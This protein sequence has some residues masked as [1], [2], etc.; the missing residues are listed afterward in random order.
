MEFFCYHRDRAGS[1]TLRNELREEHWSYMDR[2]AKELIAR[3]PTYTGD[4][5]TGSVHIVDRAGSYDSEEPRVG[6]VELQARVAAQPQ[7]FRH[8]HR[9]AT[10]RQQVLAGLGRPQ[11][12]VE[13]QSLP[14]GQHGHLAA[15]VV[16]SQAPIE[17]MEPS[18][19][20]PGQPG[21]VPGAQR[22]PAKGIG[23]EVDDLARLAG[24]SSFTGVSSVEGEHPAQHIVRNH[25]SRPRPPGR[26][27]RRGHHVDLRQARQPLGVGVTRASEDPQPAAVH[28]QTAAIQDNPAQIRPGRDL[29]LQQ[30]GTA[31]L[32]IAG[33]H[34][35][36]YVSAGQLL[37]KERPGWIIDVDQ[38]IDL[39][40]PRIVA[41]ALKT[42]SPGAPALQSTKRDG[43]LGVRSTGC[44]SV[45]W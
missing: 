4:T 3:G 13:R 22:L 32:G 27:E 5:P 15:P 7:E 29:E 17:L 21:R 2:Y 45:L 16:P 19:K 10:G 39:A 11:R 37:E 44:Y 1:V 23:G 25:E 31:C 41:P 38:L 9:T 33:Q 28:Q 36:W 34:L 35:N 26:I 8:G 12:R 43:L 20:N 42:Q 30:R 14:A 40:H 6:A 18:G 24:P